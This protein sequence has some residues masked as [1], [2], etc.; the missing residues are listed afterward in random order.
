MRD[1]GI[2]LVHS[3]MSECSYLLARRT[4]RVSHPKNGSELLQRESRC[5]RI[6]NEKDPVE[7][8]RRIT[9]IAT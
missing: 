1:L 7:R 8:F 6:P 5:Q 2:K 3:V 4:P 9:A